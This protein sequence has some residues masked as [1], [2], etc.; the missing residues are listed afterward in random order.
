MSSREELEE[1]WRT[2]LQD[3]RLS[4]DLA[5]N[6]LR[7]VRREFGAKDIPPADGHFGYQQA[8]RAENFAL[9]E[10][11]RVLKIFTDLTVP[12]EDEWPSAAAG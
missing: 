7:E 3:P 2:R 12:G 5:Q 6:Y 8:L 10:Y 9:A 4:L 11:T 1:I